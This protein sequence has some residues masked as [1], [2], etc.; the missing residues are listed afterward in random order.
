MSGLPKFLPPSTPTGTPLLAV[1]AQAMS[2]HV[3]RVCIVT[4]PIFAD[5]VHSLELPANATVI[6]AETATMSESVLTAIEVQHE[7]TIL[8]MPDTDI[9]EG[10]NPYADLS[11]AQFTSAPWG[12]AVWETKPWQ[13]GRLG[14]TLLSGD[15]VAT[16]SDKDPERDYGWHWGALSWASSEDALILPEDPHVGYALATAIDSG[17]TA[18]AIR[19]A[20]TYWDLGTPSEYARYLLRAEL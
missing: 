9:F 14:S 16:V 15:S 8:G 17:S 13:V 10:T 4:R 1:H 3:R 5:L 11:D 12:L 19:M 18:R 2:A 7:R 20:G 6:T